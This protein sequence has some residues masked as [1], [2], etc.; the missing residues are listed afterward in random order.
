ML[1]LL[2]PTKDFRYAFRR[3]MEGTD[4]AALQINLQDRGVL[5]DG[6]F[7]Q[8]TEDVVREFQDR[9]GLEVDGVAGLL[10]QRALV[11]SKCGPLQKKY[12][13]PGGILVSI[14]NNESGFAVA[15]VSLHF[16]RKGFD[17]GAFQ[18]S[19]SN[20]APQSEIEQAY[21][22]DVQAE[23]AANRLR[24]VHDRFTDPWPVESWYLREIAGGNRGHMAW[25]LAVL[26]HNW[27]AAA[28][29][30]AKT[31]HIFSD[32]DTDDMLQDWI[33]EA[34]GGR[35]STSREWVVSYIERATVYLRWPS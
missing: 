14:V 7:G 6:V 4:V 21:R 3:G 22:I 15:A 8:Q 9:N 23:G 19:T 27:P 29:N 2:Q 20:T 34:S 10:T 5:V 13:L 30:I 18:K 24:Q 35:L 28:E 11:R 16:D 17:L 32:P 12:S 33:V 25:Q 1:T 26:S 31:G